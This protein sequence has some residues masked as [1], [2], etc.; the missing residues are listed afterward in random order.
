VNITEVKVTKYES[1][2]L[3]GFASI[4]IDNEIVLTGMQIREGKNGLF[5]SMPSRKVKN[6]YRDIY[7]PIT[8]DAREQIQ[9]AVLSE[10]E[11]NNERYGIG[12]GYYP[13]DSEDDLP[14]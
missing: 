7:F 4:T 6:E 11:G 13:S 5:I 1:D 10:Y 8:R 14:I 9:N 2:S 3:K 12:E